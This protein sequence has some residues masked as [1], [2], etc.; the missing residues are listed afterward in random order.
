MNTNDPVA[1]HEELNRAFES[2]DVFNATAQDHQD[3][4]RRLSAIPPSA[5]MYGDKAQ[6]AFV[7]R[8]LTINH[9][10]MAR[11]IH[12]LEDTMRRLNSA[13]EKTQRL[14]VRLTWIAVAVGV[15]QAITA[16]ISLFR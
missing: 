14:V 16:V 13:N 5:H 4:L 3:Y 9:L 11:T 1:S 2:G 6:T 8:A 7:I 10:Q 12:E 15:V